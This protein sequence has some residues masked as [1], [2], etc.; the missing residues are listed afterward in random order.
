[1]RKDRERDVEAETGRVGL[2]GKKRITVVKE[3]HD[4]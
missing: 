2:I 3:R 1:L 4:R